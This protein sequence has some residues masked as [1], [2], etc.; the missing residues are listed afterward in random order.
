MSSNLPNN[1]LQTATWS[2]FWL[3]A[4][5]D[6]NHKIH[7]LEIDADWRIKL[8]KSTDHSEFE[9]GEF[10]SLRAESLKDGLEFSSKNTTLVYQYPWKFNQV[11]LYIPRLG[12]NLKPANKNDAHQL[13]QKIIK[14]VIEIGKTEK[15]TLIKLDFDLNFYNLLTFEEVP[16]PQLSS[17]LVT[18]QDEELDNPVNNTIRAKGNLHD[19]AG[20]L[21]LIS[22]RKVVY[23]SR[24]INFLSTIVLDVSYISSQD[25]ADNSKPSLEELQL[26]FFQNSQFWNTTNQNVRRYTK[27]SIEQKWKV[28]INNNSFED[29]YSV[30]QATVKRQNFA[31]HTKEYLQKL[32]DQE[33]AQSI[34]LRDEFGISQAAWLGGIFENT[35]IYL[36]GGNT[37]ESFKKYG[38]YLIHLVAINIASKNSCTNYDLGGWEEGKGF[39]KFKEG[40]HGKIVN[41]P[42]NFD[43]VLKQPDYFLT[44]SILLLKK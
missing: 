22:N 32:Y 23:S 1:F 16:S 4:N 15:A 6:V 38:Q 17:K 9:T 2:K 8:S 20:K 3:E 21:S 13:F 31:T 5:G 41:Y 33:F 42:G 26:L 19:S 40:Y 43:V 24:K 29:W 30:Y 27:K 14:E 7:T 39:S 11:W 10:D 44:K 34:I 18:Y 25:F 28:E 12:V 36:H 35:L 37:E